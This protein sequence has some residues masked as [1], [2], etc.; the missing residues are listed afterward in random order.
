MK[1]IGTPLGI[2]GAVAV[3][4][5]WSATPAAAA[6]TLQ[7]SQS[8]GLAAGQ[9]VTVTL[10]G[11]PANMPA[12]AV[13]QCKPQITGPADC[14]LA[15]SMLGAADGQGR[16]Q[17]NPGKGGIALVATVGTTDCAAAP[18]ACTISVTSLT[19]ATEILASVPL[20]FGPAA[21][22]PVT[23]TDA[24]EAESEDADSNT[25]MMVGIAAGVVVIAAVAVAVVIRRR[26]TN[27]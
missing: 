4:A 8:T 12:V 24:A 16:W 27:K 5:I 7:V 10:D 23:A 3:A 26:G 13:G 19:N 22:T 2:L 21:E 20:T 25:T 15:G 17:P 18:G 1:R 14:H 11:L 9:T 6:P